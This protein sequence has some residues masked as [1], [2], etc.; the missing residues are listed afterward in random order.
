[1]RFTI[2]DAATTEQRCDLDVLVDTRLLIQANSGAG[3]SWCIRRILEQTFGHVQHLVIDPEGEF[4]SLRERFDYVLAAKS[5]GDTAADPRSAKLLAHRLLELRA[6]AILDLYE[7]K[8]HERVRFVRQFLEALVDAPKALW[9]PVLVVVDEAHVYC[10]QKGEAESASAV[11]D[12]ATRGRKRGFCAILATQRLS[13]LNKDGAAECNNKLIGRSSLDVDMRRAAEELG[14]SGR[15]E[16][17]ALRDLDPGE[18]FAFGPAL[19]RT[20]ARV[21]VGGVLTTHPKAGAR[22]AFRAP[23]PTEK[24]RE[25]LPQL[26]DLPAEAEE[27][28]RT[29]E[30]AQR[31]NTRLTRALAQAKRERPA[32][33]VDEAAIERR[34]TAA[35]GI[36]KREHGAQVREAERRQQRLERALRE[37][38]GTLARLS[39]RMLAAL[40][41]SQ[42][43]PV[44]PEPLERSV[45]VTP[46]AAYVPPAASPE[47]LPAD[48]ISVPQQR[49]LDVLAAFRGLGLDQVHKNMVAVHARAS[50]TSG[51]YFN[52]L[53]RLR[54]LGLIDYPQPSYVSLTDAG[55]EQAHD[56]EPITG[57]EEL[58]E[59]WYRILPRP[60]AAILRALIDIYPEAMRKDDLAAQV[61][62]SPTSGGYFNNLGRLRTLGAVEYPSPG[63]V[64]AADILWPEGVAALSS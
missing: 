11:I 34:V 45:R 62:V 16:Q 58:H 6:S 13:K 19:C 57:V 40:N 42:E 15:E 8:A 18:F 21:K 35:V 36:A 4:A 10:P 56:V 3:K 44:P 9:H 51:G 46:P 27:H 54:S 20:V 26:A 63:M 53:G 33:T 37:G 23:P 38:A 29:L 55:A 22:L 12:L 25:L 52:N 61:D 49:I 59:S 5:G 2:G 28:R 17:A 1:M 30:G 60:Q 39:E 14:F 43:R 50:P 24:V 41:G 31:E 64:R 7:L 48:G 32:A 47:P